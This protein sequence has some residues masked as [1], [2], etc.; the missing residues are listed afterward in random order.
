[1]KEYGAASSP[2][3]RPLIVG[4]DND[5]VIQSIAA[6]HGFAAGR[7]GESDRP[8][9]VAVGRGLAPA[10]G[11]GDRALRQ[12][13]SRHRN[14]IVPIHN[15]A[16]REA[17][18]RRGAI[19][20]PFAQGHARTAD[21]A[22]HTQGSRRQKPADGSQADRANVKICEHFPHDELS[23]AAAFKPALL[24]VTSHNRAASPSFRACN[25]DHD[26][27]NP[28]CRRRRHAAR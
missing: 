21:K 18:D 15:P 19:A 1:M 8:V 13:R 20:F 17:A 5:N 11:R 24:I 4:E 16:Q 25:H 12:T 6:G 23:C 2:D 26:Q 9:V 28:D 10:V 7:I 3:A 22:G 27:E 14:A